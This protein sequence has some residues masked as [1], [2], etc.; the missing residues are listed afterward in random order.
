LSDALPC[1]SAYFPAVSRCVGLGTEG[2]QVFFGI[3][4][5]LAAELIVRDF[6]I[7]HRSAPLTPASHRDAA[8]TAGEFRTLGD[9]IASYGASGQLSS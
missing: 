8:Q 5:R 2:D 7:P 4:A 3:F 6:D 1:E 9:P